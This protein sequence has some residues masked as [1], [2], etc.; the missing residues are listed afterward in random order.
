MLF[1]NVSVSN[2]NRLILVKSFRR[3]RMISI[4]ID[5]NKEM[6]FDVKFIVSYL[7]KNEIKIILIFL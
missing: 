1:L 4:F 6:K 5:N 3:V 2:S 7:L